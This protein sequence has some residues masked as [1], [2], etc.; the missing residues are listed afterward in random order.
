MPST[1]SD[2]FADLLALQQDMERLFE[3]LG[4]SPHKHAVEGASFAPAT[5]VFRRD[6]DILIHLDLPGLDPR[7]ISVSVTGNQI[8]VRGTRESR[9]D[10]AEGDYVLRE[11]RHGTFERRITMPEEIEATQVRAQYRAGVLEVTVPRSALMPPAER[12]VAVA[13]SGNAGGEVR[14]PQ[15]GGTGP[16][17]ASTV[18]AT[19]TAGAGGTNADVGET[20]RE[21]QQVTPAPDVGAQGTAQETDDRQEQGEPA[22]RSFAQWL[23][24][25]P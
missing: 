10:V 3:Q 7:G 14:E 20:G 4:A 15:R 2:P 19:D 6:G 25:E 24:Q 23:R 22:R 11:A 8:A 21:G 12:P 13:S 18:P 1:V 5:D 16:G 9:Q 17:T